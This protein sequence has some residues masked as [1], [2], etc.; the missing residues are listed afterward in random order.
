MGVS[1]VNKNTKIRIAAF[2]SL[3]AIVIFIYKFDFTILSSWRTWNLPLSGKIIVLDP[4]HGGPD[5][6]ASG[7][8]IIEKEVS[9]KISLLLRDYLQEQGAVVI[10]TRQSDKD[11]ASPFTK[12]YSIR[13]TEDLRKRLKIINKSD[14]DMFLSIHLNSLPIA[15]YSGAQTFYNIG[16]DDNKELAA[17]IQDELRKTLNNTNRVA[18]PIHNIYLLRK[19]EIPG[20]L[21]EAGFLSNATER[22]LLADEE[23]QDKIAFGIYKGILRSLTNEKA[24]EE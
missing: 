23:Y 6:G 5:G 22:A 4:G 13:K 12:G 11:L 20:A 9:L 19:A 8:E 15:K 1:K 14:A 24:P 3:I 21:V 2:I 18:K 16:S 10:M 17:F 7:G